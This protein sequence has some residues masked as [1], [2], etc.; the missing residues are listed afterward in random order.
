MR[1][2]LTAIC[3]SVALP[4]GAQDVCSIVHGAAVVADDGKFLGKLTNKFDSES[5]LNEFGT[6]GS[7]FSSDSIWNE[8]ASYGGKFSNLSPFNQFTSS[9]PVLVKGGKA[10]AYLT[11]N[12]HL[13]GALN[14]YIVK[15]CDF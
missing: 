10:L 5:I 11:V 15:S 6:H 12:K 3:L 14:P 13:P 4:V 1:A 9:P 8:F 7:K 2:C